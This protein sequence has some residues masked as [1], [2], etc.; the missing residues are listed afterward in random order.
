MSTNSISIGIHWRFIFNTIWSFLTPYSAR[1]TILLWFSTNNNTYSY[2]LI[3]KKAAG[4]IS[5]TDLCTTNL[6]S[7]MCS[8]S[9]YNRKFLTLCM[10]GN[11]AW[12][13]LLSCRTFSSIFFKTSRWISWSHVQ[14]VRLAP[15]LK[16]IFHQCVISYTCSQSNS[17]GS[18]LSLTLMALS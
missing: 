4:K 15:V 2:Y 9:C 6:I 8:S 16:T 3:M 12:F 11:F 7:N 13:L 17:D 10:L 1:P 14:T 18:V 5:I